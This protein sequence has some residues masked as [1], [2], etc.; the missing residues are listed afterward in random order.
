[1]ALTPLKRDSFGEPYVHSPVAKALN[2]T[3]SPSAL[4]TYHFCR[5]SGFIRALETPCR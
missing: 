2:G 3:I 1:M 4:R 5:S